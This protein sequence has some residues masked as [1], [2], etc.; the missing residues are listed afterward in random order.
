MISTTVSA[1]ATTINWFGS[2][3][4]LTTITDSTATVA[5]QPSTTVSGATALAINFQQTAW[6]TVYFTPA[7]VWNWSQY[8]GMQMQLSN[9]SSSIATLCVALEDQPSTS[10]TAS[11]HIAWYFVNIPADET[12]NFAFP[13]SSS[14]AQQQS[15]D[16]MQT[17]PP[18]FPGLIGATSTIVSG[19]NSSHIYKMIFYMASP[20]TAQN[21]VVDSVSLVKATPAAT[22]L[23]G[24]V[25]SY[26]QFNRTT[27]PNKVT[28][29][30][31]IATQESVEQADLSAHPAA[32]TLWDAY[33]GWA[34]G[35]QDTPG[36]YFRVVCQQ[37]K[38]WFVDP[39]GHLFFS[40]GV[41]G[42]APDQDSYVTGRTQMFTS[43]PM[44]SATTANFYTHNLSLR[45][46]SSY[47][48]AW[49]AKTFKRF[50]SWGFNTLGDWA[51]P[52]FMTNSK[53]PYT[54][55]QSTSGTY[56]TINTGADLWGPMPDP[57]DPRFAA[58]CTWSFAYAANGKQN[59]P[60]LLGYFIDNELSW[61][62]PGQYANYGIPIAVL[63]Q[64]ASTSSAKQA[65][66]SQLQTEYSTI[67]KLNTAWKTAFSSWS[68]LSTPYVIPATP[69][70]AQLADLS[71]LLTLYAN[72]YFSVVRTHL[73]SADPNHLY[74]GCKFGQVTPKE[75]LAAASAYCDVLSFDLYQ[76]SIDPATAAVFASTYKPCLIAEFQFA[77]TDS[78]LFWGSCSP[79]NTQQ[80]RAAA[81]STYV[82]SA[83]TCPYVIGCYW[84]QYTDDP[85]T[86]TTFD[87]ENGNIG[88]VD[89]TDTVY[90]N[91]V[92]MARS[93]NSS[94]YANRNSAE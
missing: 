57:F 72:Q 53:L 78:G 42:V 66:V 16:G 86:G 59:D 56:N 19:F 73:K 77:A 7:T 93:V 10:S 30:A 88:F 61:I 71:K 34:A 48:S 43:T 91:L 17:A 79:V 46:G 31:D 25:D 58:T 33:G 11:T 75:V 41:D 24:F 89:V 9:T 52:E 87:G 81:Y 76:K 44:D 38:W 21:I 35:P 69:N 15:E 18:W 1:H 55:D 63:D 5:E 82:N 22:L 83:A 39:L 13:L 29:N 65:F 85:V 12:L 2:G 64:A 37:N 74:L 80:D 20:A 6:P 84:F 62:G 40:T 27:W 94:V 60:M 54:V 3:S 23:D 8:D 28:S 49:I 68:A 4:S 67:A 14:F 50:K 47:Q 90:Q 36:K 92:S 26:G 32:P 45:Y 51:D 70:A